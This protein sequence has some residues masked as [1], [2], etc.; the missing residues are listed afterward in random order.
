MSSLRLFPL[1]LF[2]RK[3]LTLQSHVLCQQAKHIVDLQQST[4]LENGMRGKLNIHDNRVKQLHESAI[5]RES[6]INYFT[7][8]LREIIKENDE[9]EWPRCTEELYYKFVKGPHDGITNEG[10]EANVQITFQRYITSM[11]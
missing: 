11:I 8:L 10:L 7:H 6:Y 1:I 5:E 4:Y 3:K 2:Q 9:H